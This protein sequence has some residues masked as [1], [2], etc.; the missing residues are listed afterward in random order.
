MACPSSIDHHVFLMG[1]SFGVDVELVETFAN[2]PKM[3][4]EEVKHKK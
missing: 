4:F 2:W 3:G 1:K